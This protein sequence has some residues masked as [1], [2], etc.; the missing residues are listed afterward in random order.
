MLST[1]LN[2]LG[3]IL[4]AKTIKDIYPNV[5]LANCSVGEN[6][7]N[8]LFDCQQTISSNELPKIL[9]QVYKNIDRNF[10]ITYES[11]PKQEALNCF[12]NNVY[13]QELINEIKTENVDVVKLNNECFDICEN[14]N[15]TKFSNIKS[16]NLFNVSGEY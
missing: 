7:F 5:L 14:L 6:G 11:V 4:L 2:K 1:Q 8:Y 3:A 13:K 9:K 15:I 16:I 10:S 12:S